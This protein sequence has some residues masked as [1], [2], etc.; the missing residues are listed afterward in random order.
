MLH[1]SPEEQRWLDAYRQILDDQFPGL[2]EEFLIFGSKARG[3][4]T[5][6]SDLDL[7]LV[8]REGDW[9]RKE[10]I[11]RP[12]NMLAIG[13]EVVPSFV[14]YT[15]EEWEQ[16]REDRAPFWQTVTRDGVPVL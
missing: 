6:D 7:L 5:P 14:V 13:T 3:D 4:S 9:R 2:V 15:R 10:E 1:L 16:R 8:I 12:G 11:T